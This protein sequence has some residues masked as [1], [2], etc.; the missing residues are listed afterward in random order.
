MPSPFKLIACG[1]FFG[2][3]MCAEI[4]AQT[5]RPK[6]ANSELQ[7]HYDAAQHDQQAGNL[8]SA[9]REYRAFL[10]KA[11]EELALG[12]AAIGDDL[13]ATD[14]FEKAVA[15]QSDNWE[16]R[17]EFARAALAMNDPSRAETQ[18]RA[19]IGGIHDDPKMLAD[20]HQV[21]GRA[22]LKKN[23]DSEARK[24]ME[25]AVKLNP[26][27]PNGY[28]LAVVC[29][30]LDD[31]KCVTQIFEE[32]ER[33][34]GDTP[35]IHMQ[36]G[37]AYGNS[38]FAPQAIAEF[39]KVIA[40]NPNLPRAHY[41][42]AAALLSAGDDAKNMPEAAAELKKELEISPRDFLTYAALGKLA[43]SSHQY[44]A[45]EGYLK[46]AIDLN[47][48]NPDAFL[49]LGQM[50]FDTDRQADAESALRK[51]IELTK[52][53]S[54]NRFQ[55]QKAHFLL[56]R[57]LMQEHK[58]EAAHAEMAIAQ[59]F[60]NKG[61][62]HDKSE[63]A[64]LLNNSTVTGTRDSPEDAHSQSEAP[65]QPLNASAKNDLIVFEKRLTPAIAD[66]YNN[67]GVIAASGKN[68]MDALSEFAKASQWS[69]NLEGLDLNW[70]RSAFMASQFSEAIGPLSRFIRAH[71]E[72]SGVRGALAM[73]QFMTQ[74]YSGC[75]ATFK[76]AGDKLS[77]IPQ[78]EYVYAESL[79]HTGET[80]EGKSRLE[81]L[82]TAHPEIGEVHRSL[83]E[84]YELQ[85]DGVKASRELHTAIVLN[86]NDADAHYDL[87][88]TEVAGRDVAGAI[89][90][91][92]AATR[93]APEN[94][95]FHRE[96]AVAYRLAQRKVDEE[97]E[98][99]IYE[100]LKNPPATEDKATEPE[101]NPT[102]K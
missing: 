52:D 48:N 70:G 80:S 81:A 2:L 39:R 82:E 96:L 59:S 47:P 91:L 12:H 101:R 64:G 21:L 65:A 30:D 9:A 38:D 74:D 5:K 11:Q 93:I 61:L 54:R 8:D 58:P 92:E 40:E 78:M 69:P 66:S 26:S 98:L 4:L 50:Y 22:L 23:E 3:S 44:E 1:T 75:I 45:A 33:S 13:R 29:L 68:Y 95:A 94:P 88:K 37:F 79:V 14:L 84:V 7:D 90:E 100:R 41:S 42:L 67:L 60:A 17:L 31:E 6:S 89:Q 77:S 71:P 16:I 19:M 63:L 102:T 73:S 24:D 43:V 99:R 18:A 51:A 97:G 57:I 55:V 25:E 53:P 83:G 27:F 35:E 28:G 56:G 49:Y 85:G 20:A 10:A 32:M 87:G 86:A 15:M 36:F 76:A 72:D 34:F 62:S 46:R